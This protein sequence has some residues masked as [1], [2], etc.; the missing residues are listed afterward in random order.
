[1]DIQ[2]GRYTAEYH[3]DFVVF[4]IGMRIN[5]WWR[6]REWLPVVRAARAMTVEAKGL[7]GS[8]LLESRSFTSPDDLRN[9]L[10]IQYWRSFDE[11]A[12][13]ASDRDLQHRPAQAAFFRRTAYNGH[14][15]IWHET[16]RVADGN[17]EAI[18]ANMP[19][20][21]LAAAGTYRPLDHG[22]RARDRM[23]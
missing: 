17:Y 11:L 6:V 3:G 19:R 12:A 13:W 15:G 7:P 1:M 4:L 2:A 18:Y 10:F 20:F 14:V 8:P 22:S 23:R 5:S 16:F 21:G 9:H